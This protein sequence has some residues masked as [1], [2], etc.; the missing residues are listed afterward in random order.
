MRLTNI[1]NQG[2]KV[3]VF[4][5]DDQGNQTI[6]ED[7]SLFPYYYEVGEDG[8]LQG[9]D[10]KKVKRIFVPQPRDIYDQRTN[11]SYEADI[12]FTRKYLIDKVKDIE[13]CPVKYAFIDIEI[14]L[15]DGRF[16]NV[17]KAECPVSC[18]SIYNSESKD[19]KTFF[20]L[21][22]KT[23][24]NM[25]EAFVE[26]MKEEKFDLWLSW[27][28][29]FDYDYLHNRFPDLPKQ[30]SP[31]GQDRYAHDEVRYPAGMSIVDYMEWFK[32]I[33][34]N[35]HSSYALDSIAEDILGKGKVNKEVDF[36]LV[37][38]TVRER[39]RE[40][41]QIMAD[42]EAKK[43][44]IPY[45]DNI[46]KLAKVEWE[47]MTWNSRVIDSL[48]LQEAKKQNLVLPMK[49]K[50]NEK[51]DFEGAY[52]EAYS[53]GAHWN[54]GKYDLSS[55]YPNMIIDFCLDPSNITG[56][57]ANPN[58]VENGQ[59]NELELIIENTIFEQNDTALLPIVCKKVLTLKQE[60]GKE[61]KSLS[62]QDE[63]YED[64]KQRY[65]AIKTIVNSAYGVMGNRFFRLYDNRVASA[66]TFLVRD[67]L[68]FVR[69]RLEAEGKKVIYVDTDSVFIDSEEDLTD[70]LNTLISEWGQKYGKTNI[71]TQFEYEGSFEKLLILA[72]CLDPRTKILTEDGYKTIQNMYATKYEGQ[73][74]S[75]NEKFEIF[76][77]KRV[78]NYSKTKLNNRKLFKIILDCKKH[79]K[80]N[81]GAIIT[82]DH[83]ILTKEGYKEVRNL[84]KTDKINTGTYLPNKEIYSALIGTLL[85][86]SSITK[87]NFLS[88]S[89]SK[90][91]EDYL[92]FKFNIIS[93]NW[94]K[95][96]SKCNV[97][98]KSYS[99]IKGH[100]SELYLRNLR[101]KLYPKGEKTIT[102]EILKDY[103][104]ISL[105]FQYMDDGYLR[106][107]KYFSSEIATC[108][109]DKKSLKLL[110]DHI[111]KMGFDHNITK[112]NR[113]YFTV[114]QTKK[115]SK[116]IS[117]YVPKCMEYKLLPEDRNKEKH[118]FNYL[119][120]IYYDAFKLKEYKPKQKS[121]Y[122]ITVQDNENFLTESGVIHN[123][124][125]IGYIR[126]TNGE[127][128]EEIKGVEAK[129][130]DSTKYMK[131]FQ[132]DLVEKILNKES[133]ESIYE[134]ILSEIERIKTLPLTEVSFPCKL[135]RDPSQYSNRPIFL[136]AMEETEGFEKKVGEK[137][138]YIYVKPEYYHEEKEVVEF[139]REVPGKRPGT[140][141][142]QKLK[143][144]EVKELGSKLSDLIT[145]GEIIRTQRIAK[146]K[147]AKDVKAFDRF[148]EDNIQDVDW[149]RMI[150]RNILMKLD[151]IFGAMSWDLNEIKEKRRSLSL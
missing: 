124:R 60:I 19:I 8:D 148:T 84:N 106:Q 117:K 105:A 123:C 101:S 127:L 129:R 79:D 52:R 120:R 57:N 66:T 141:K 86:D 22:Y 146:T 107:E 94:H 25:L 126:K 74:W 17:S 85:G 116:A 131:T 58:T 69:D 99:Y 51:E 45:Y 144:A 118:E 100:F 44:V 137:Y 71:S 49:P 40:D 121:V 50:D 143:V 140:T 114:K 109:F 37:D 136:R 132:K 128:E 31:I 102:K 142:K 3:F 95:K 113:L 97:K 6:I 81:Y 30:I 46:R 65:N 111:K 56:G 77:Q 151:T 9:Y 125:Y 7:S 41:V 75:Y 13:S 134:W 29:Q 149:E 18:I 138:Y 112:D 14:Q 64:I 27:N 72:K 147:K 61:L 115:L 90:K 108:G 76:E 82:E 11:Q 89:H 119:R 12:P 4:G 62:T 59:L 68:H 91:Q 26:Y 83:E 139:H 98:G 36:T 96:E 5:R 93:E 130:K 34:L 78:L 10:G 135:A 39:N 103:N 145:S 32:K 35:K 47:D 54:I 150:E 43:K 16:P 104:I 63:N 38:E 73:V 28:V 110:S 21:D 48:V 42:L 23:E 15:K 133:K 70:Y 1:H 80:R 67:L 24:Y 20:L 2:R 92:D 88:C 122:D 53:L 87:S 33:T 55:A